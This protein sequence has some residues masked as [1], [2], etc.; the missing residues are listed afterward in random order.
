MSS[1]AL[2]ALQSLAASKE[3]APLR[4][5]LLGRMQGTSTRVAGRNL[6]GVKT[7]MGV[8]VGGTDSQRGILPPGGVRWFRVLW[9]Q[10]FQK[11]YLGPGLMFLPWLLVHVSSLVEGFE[12]L[13]I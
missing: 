6:E 4:S 13:F 11:P 2:P 10:L 5:G 12:D 8:V 1:S 9:V 3:D 7:S